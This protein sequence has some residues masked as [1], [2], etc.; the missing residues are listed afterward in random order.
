MFKQNWELID[1][2]PRTTTKT[3]QELRVG[4]KVL[5]ENVV[6]KYLSFTTKTI[7]VY[8]GFESDEPWPMPVC[9]PCF[10]NPEEDTINHCP[11]SF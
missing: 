7:D 1:I 8:E 2:G 10:Y 5:F 3:I 4:D 9:N 6:K 11:L